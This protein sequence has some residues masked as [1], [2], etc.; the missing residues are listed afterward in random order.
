MKAQFLYVNIYDFILSAKVALQNSEKYWGATVPPLQ[1]QSLKERNLQGWKDTRWKFHAGYKRLHVKRAI[2]L[3]I[4]TLASNFFLPG[5]YKFW[6]LLGVS[7]IFPSLRMNECDYL[8]GF[9]QPSC[10]V[11]VSGC[12]NKITTHFIQMLTSLFPTHT[13]HYLMW[14]PSPV[15]FTLP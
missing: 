14:K 11:L 13:I 12:F 7:D 3:N 9:Q 10:S 2:Y 6:P 5:F 8:L 15:F 1:P 4:F